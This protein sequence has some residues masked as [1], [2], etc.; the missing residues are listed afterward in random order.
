MSMQTAWWRPRKPVAMDPQPWPSS[1]RGCLQKR[2]GRCCVSASSAR[3]HRVLAISWLRELAKAD[4][5]LMWMHYKQIGRSFPEDAARHLE[6][7]IRNE[8]TRT[9][10]RGGYQRIAERVREFGGYAGSPSMSKL[11]DDLLSRY[12]NRPAMIA[13]L[14]KALGKA[15]TPS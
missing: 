12:L 14:G 9:H 2:P 10:S 6:Q 13:E 8:L 7:G 3:F 15:K 5:S 1:R 11:V 4:A